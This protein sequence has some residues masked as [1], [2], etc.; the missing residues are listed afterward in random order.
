MLTEDIPTLQDTELSQFIDCIREKYGYDFSD[1]SEASLKRR[2]IR[3]MTNDQI[4]NLMELQNNILSNPVLLNRFVEEITVNVTEMFRD[5]S[6][7]RALIDEVFPHLAKEP[8][9]RVWH[10]GCST[11]EEVFSLAILLKEAGLLNKSLLYATDI[12]QSVLTNAANRTFSLQCM[13]DYSD[14]Y[15][16]S[17]GKYKLSDY[18]TKNGDTAV[19]AEELSKR[20]VFSHHNLA[21]DQS[22]NEFNLILCRNVLIYFNRNLQ[23][24]VFTLFNDSMAPGGFLA[25]GS[26]ETIEFSSISEEFTVIDKKN[27]IWIKK[28]L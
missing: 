7:Y 22:F 23:N 5:P 18:Y 3:L 6:F 25:L 17:G 16:H 12:N 10:A 21:I 28:K 26:K 24:R 8:L 13:K 4:P 11:G 1:Y 9:I 14:N 19:L 2:I 20:M 27:K 15:L